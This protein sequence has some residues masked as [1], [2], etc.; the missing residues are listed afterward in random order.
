MWIYTTN[1][2]RD[3]PTPPT[4]SSP[5]TANSEV[6]KVTGPSQPAPLP[7]LPFSL[8]CK[9]MSGGSSVAYLSVSGSFLS[10]EK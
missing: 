8:I 2:H 10:R 5:S 6:S 7:D 9:E 1:S 3:F 4:Q